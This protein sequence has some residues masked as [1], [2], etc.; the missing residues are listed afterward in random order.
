MAVDHVTVRIPELPPVN[1]D[2]PLTDDD[3]MPIWSADDNVTRHTKLST[4]RTYIET[5]AATGVNPVV[6]GAKVLYIVPESDAGGTVASIPFLAGESF[7]LR[8]DGQPMVPE[9]DPS[10]AEPAE[11]RVLSSGGFQLLRAGEKLIAGQRYELEVFTMV[12]GGTTIPVI[13]GGGS[14]EISG[15]VVVTTNLT[16]TVSNHLRK[17][18]QLRAGASKVVITLPSLL[19]IP[20]NTIINIEASV[21]NSW[22]NRITTQGGQNIYM[23]NQSFTSIY[24]APGESLRLY[25]D[26]DGFYM[27]SDFGQYYRSVGKIESTYKVHMNQVLADGSLL[28][29]TDYPRLW[30]WVQGLGSSLVSEATWNTASVVVAGKEVLRPFRGCYSTGDGSTTFRVP[31][32]MNVALR[33][34]KSVLGVDSQRHQNKPGIFQRHEFPAHDH[35]PANNASGTDFGLLGKSLSF[36]DAKT[37]G[38]VDNT[39]RGNEP[40]IVDSPTKMTDGGGGTET[41]MDNVGIFWTINT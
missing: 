11:Y 30:E 17:L 14:G 27:M 26:E 1:E 35:T 13:S 33:G 16:M 25:R 6:N 7:N 38:S 4:L 34:V 8:R 9:T 39:G 20:V 21:L 36:S 10:G 2:H 22:Q 24:I 41:R 31:D 28:N 15:K 32:L 5:G 40:N 3:T 12:G 37:V 23:N 29:R 18:I 19:D